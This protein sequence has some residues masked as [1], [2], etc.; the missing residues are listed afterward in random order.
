MCEIELKHW[1]T[2]RFNV[3]ATITD[4]ASFI[5]TFLTRYSTVFLNP[6]PADS[7]QSAELTGTVSYIV[8]TQ[9][10]DWC[11]ASVS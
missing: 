8:T 6:S 10:A 7:N 2:L 4:M 5:S 11:R 1:K 3:V 9:M